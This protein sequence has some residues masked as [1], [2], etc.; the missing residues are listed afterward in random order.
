METIILGVVMFTVVVVA[1]VS[2]L[3]AAKVKNWSTVK[4]SPFGIN[5][6]PDK[7]LKTPAGDTL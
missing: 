3:L 2:V 7:V 4:K 5:E 6:D 1:L